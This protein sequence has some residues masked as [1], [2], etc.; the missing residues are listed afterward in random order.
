MRARFLAS[1]AVPAIMATLVTPA[2]AQ[3]ADEGVVSDDIIVTA[4]KVQERLQDVPVA[5]SAFTGE[6]LTEKGAVN[7][8][9][10][11]SLAS[12]LSIRQNGSNTTAVFI[13]LRGQVV[14]EVLATIEPSIGTYV[15]ELY[16]S[17]A[18][19]LNASLL[20]VTNV[21]VLKGPQGTLFGRNTTGGAIVVTS[22]DPNTD[23]FSGSADATYGRFNEAA[24][25]LVLNVPLSQQIAVRGAFH[26]SRR[27]GW[28]TSVRQ[29]NKATGLADNN[30][31][32]PGLGEIRPDGRKLRDLDELQGRAKVLFQASDTTKVILSGEWFRSRSTPGRQLFYKVN[33]NDASD[34]VS[35]NTPALAYAEYFRNHP[36]AMGSDA[37]DCAYAPT[38][39]AATNCID[40]IRPFHHADD[41]TSSQTYVAKIISETGLGQLKVIGGYRQI[42]VK[43]A[44][45]VDGSAAPIHTTTLEQDL[46]SWSGE[47]QLTGRTLADRLS[48]AVGATYFGEKGFDLSYSGS[49]GFGGVGGVRQNRFT[50][51]YG[52]IDN[53][54]VGVY[55]QATYKLTD[56]LGFT[57]GLRYSHDKKGIQIR[58]AN[59]NLAGVPTA[60]LAGGDPCNAAL[61][62]VVTGATA[63]N[64]CAV[65]RSANSSALSWTA[66]LDYKFTPD[67]MVYA[68]ASKGYRAGGQ[69]MRAF[70]DIQFEPF[71][72]ETLTEFEL[73]LKAEFLDRAVRFN[74]AGYRNT[75]ND[76]QRNVNVVLGTAPNQVS[77][78]QIR[79]AAKVRNTGFEA[80]LTLRPVPG[81]T[82]TASGSYNDSKYLDY[83]E[84]ILVSGVEVVKSLNH[85]RILLIPKYTLNFSGAYTTQLN[86]ETSLT[87]NADYSYIGKTAQDPCTV[88]FDAA[89]GQ[90]DTRC[91]KGG[92]DQ[93]GRTAAQISQDIFDATTLPA[94]GVLNARLTVGLKN[95]AYTFSIWGRNILNDTSRVSA[96]ALSAAQ[97]NYV[98]GMTR[99]PVMYGV[100]AGAKF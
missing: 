42:A 14:N 45:D 91:W 96:T 48:Y 55:G 4:R 94:S 49:T 43:T 81:L 32:A 82:L 30:Y 93:T 17:R 12:G 61:S 25:N 77:S 65:S 86:D 63:A 78:T 70:N 31:L 73:G 95:D 35:A 84:S 5:I 62:G 19:G 41:K 10:V 74:I 58:S 46:D 89:A 67:V 11:G 20:D 26:I 44:F 72:P 97:R 71:K 83:N 37:F 13:A 23:S 59:V 29:Y 52:Y 68:K 88:T 15:D 57:G 3:Q 33:L 54:S 40:N 27:D 39:G 34:S 1:I 69:N 24:A 22:N 6:Q 47:V 90:S 66:G 50:R 9:D 100:T 36:S 60:I 51:N 16:W 75:L 28:A 79:N 85:T 7:I 64:D 21:Q 92:A 80:D 53:E 18:Y 87:L 2:F 8:A 38:A 56:Q 76:A 99:P 98:S